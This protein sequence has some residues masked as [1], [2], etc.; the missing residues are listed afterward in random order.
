MVSDQVALIQFWCLADVSSVSPSSEQT[1]YPTG[2]KQTISTFVDQT[3]M[4]K[5][6]TLNMRNAMQQRQVL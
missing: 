3:P 6:Q 4:Q 1:P 2:E 5:P